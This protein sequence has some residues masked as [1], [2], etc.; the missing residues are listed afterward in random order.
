MPTQPRCNR[1]LRFGVYQVDLGSGQLLKRGMDVKLQEQPFQVLS[2]LLERPGELVTRE[3]LRHELWTDDTFV[4]FDRSLNTA[5]TKL[6][7]ALSDSAEKP[8]LH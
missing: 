5:V 3:K 1:V 7:R 6:R 4:D 8:P 2:T